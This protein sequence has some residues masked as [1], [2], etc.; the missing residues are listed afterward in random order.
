MNIILIITTAIAVIAYMGGLAFV[1]VIPIQNE[2]ISKWL[3]RLSM[4][5]GAVLVGLTLYD[6]SRGGGGWFE[7]PFVGIICLLVGIV[8]SHEGFRSSRKK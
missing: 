7:S 5:S 4:L 1:V 3:F 8:F 6:F 2:G